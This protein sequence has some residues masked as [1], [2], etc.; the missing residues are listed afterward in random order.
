MEVN[1]LRQKSE[2]E[3]R[4]LLKDL[5]RELKELKIEHRMEGLLDTSELGKIRKAIARAKTVL[6]EKEVLEEIK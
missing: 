3:L 2:K 5:E 1:E 6:R 4:G